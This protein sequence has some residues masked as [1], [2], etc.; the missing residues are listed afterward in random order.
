MHEL[1]TP[2]HTHMT[3]TYMDTHIHTHTHTHTHTE[4]ACTTCSDIGS[5]FSHKVYMCM[6]V[7]ACAHTHD[8]HIHAHTHTHT[9]TLTQTGLVTL[10]VTLG[11]SFSHCLYKAYMCMNV[12][13][14]IKP[15][16]RGGSGV[17]TNHPPPPPKGSRSAYVVRSRL[18]KLLGLRT[19]PQWGSLHRSPPPPPPCFVMDLKRNAPPPPHF[20]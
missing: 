5:Y 20:S 7:H 18:A 13:T 1:Y 14:H 17:R 16:A 15:I 9:H 6:N 8:T 11:S 10:A 2:V 3:H 12:H 4:R 19:R